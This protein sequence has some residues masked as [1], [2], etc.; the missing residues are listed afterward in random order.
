MTRG[1]G[2]GK[3]AIMRRFRLFDEGSA[4][5]R[6]NVFLALY[7]W[8]YEIGVVIA[9]VAVFRLG[10]ATHWT[11]AAAVA[12]AA[13]GGVVVWPAARG[14]VAARFRCAVTQ[15]RLRTAFQE[16]GLVTLR[17]RMPAIL[18]C[19][20]KKAGIRVLVSLCAGLEV[21]DLVRERR[22]LAAACFASDV[23]VERHPSYANIIVLFVVTAA[24]A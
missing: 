1:G 18:W 3:K 13:V 6:P 24:Q 2:D 7:R 11:V 8:R 22:V 17:G 5:K 19:T 14:F 12:V 20:P 15:H 9:G 10:Q 16:A 21:A 23:Y 4:R